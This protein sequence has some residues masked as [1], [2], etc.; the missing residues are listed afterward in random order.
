[1][2]FRTLRALEARLADIPEDELDFEV[3]R[4]IGRESRLAWKSRRA[5]AGRNNDDER[6]GDRGDEVTK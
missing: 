2:I 4:I 5:V 3:R 1:M 6:H